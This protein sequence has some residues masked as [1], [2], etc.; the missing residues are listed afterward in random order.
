MGATVGQLVEPPP[1]APDLPVGEKLRWVLDGVSDMLESGL[2]RGA[3]AAVIADS[4][5]DFTAALRAQLAARLGAVTELMELDVRAGVLD[6]RVDP[7]TLAGLLV[8]AYL[9]EVLRF[10]T[11]RDGWT[12]RAIELLAPAVTPHR[13]TR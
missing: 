3:T 13:R 1:L 5:P 6:S 2:G 4:D 12:D 10:G 11:P 9:A 7:D 8:G